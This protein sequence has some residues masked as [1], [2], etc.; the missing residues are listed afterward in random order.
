VG[1]AL[2]PD[3][4]LFSFSGVN[5]DSILFLGEMEVGRPPLSLAAGLR[6]PLLRSFYFL[7]R[8]FFPPPVLSRS[9]ALETLAS[10]FVE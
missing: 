3:F 6:F 8:L 10:L 5:A 1:F 4:L 7:F 2:I 9:H